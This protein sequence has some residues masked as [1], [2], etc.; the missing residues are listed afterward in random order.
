MDR[1]RW[2]CEILEFSQALE[3]LLESILDLDEATL[4]LGPTR[5]FAPT[6][7]TNKYNQH[8][9]TTT[10]NNNDNNRERVAFE[11]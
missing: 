7:S 9:N 5:A 10:T 2:M 6:I 8:Y 1:D 3:V 4:Y 11:C